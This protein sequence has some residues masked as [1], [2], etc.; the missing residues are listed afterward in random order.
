MNTQSR[1][2]NNV[3]WIDETATQLIARRA[4]RLVALFRPC[5]HACAASSRLARQLFHRTLSCVQLQFL[6]CRHV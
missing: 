5:A 2:F 3:R 4:S 1:A 6:G